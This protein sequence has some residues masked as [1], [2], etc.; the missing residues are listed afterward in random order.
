M[1]SEFALF[2]NYFNNKY[3]RLQFQGC[4]LYINILNISQMKINQIRNH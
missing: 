2:L 4:L 1:Y 3:T